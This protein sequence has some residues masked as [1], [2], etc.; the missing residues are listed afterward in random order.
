MVQE[1]I[2]RP[3][4]Y[5]QVLALRPGMAELENLVL[6]HCDALQASKIIPTLIY[7]GTKT[8]CL[9]IWCT[10]V[11]RFCDDMKIRPK[12]VNDVNPRDD[13]REMAERC[14]GI[15]YASLSPTLIRYTQ[16]D[17][18]AGIARQL[19]NGAWG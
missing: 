19:I 16:E 2:N 14:I 7:S 12:P 5:Y 6:A 3:N 8:D 11:E 1:T 13:C 10:L 18:E 15:I 9:K 17:L 4:L